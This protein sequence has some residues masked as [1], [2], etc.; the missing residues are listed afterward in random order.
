MDALGIKWIP[1]LLNVAD[2]KKW[3]KNP[4]KISDGA[5]A[6]LKRKIL[7]EGMHQV[8]TI[9]TDNTVLSGNQRLDILTELEWK[10]VW[11]MV[12]ERA[13]TPQERDKV[14]I[15]ANIIEGEWDSAILA[16][17]FDIPMLTDQGIKAI[18]LPRI[19]TGDEDNVPEV[20]PEAI[21][22]RGDIFTLGEH[23]LMC[24][25]ATSDEDM[26]KLM[27]G[28]RSNML[29]TD[30]PWN[31]G[32]GTDGNPKHKQRQGLV[33]DALGQDFFGFLV[34]SAKI[35][36]A[37]NDGDIY[38][39]MGCEQWPTIHAA[40]TGEGL[41]WSAT[42]IWVKDIFVLGRS[43]YHRRYEPIWY[44]WKEKSTYVADRKQDDVWEIPRPKRSDEHPTMKPVELMSRAILNSSNERD[45]VLDPFLG[46][47]STMVAAEKNRRKCYGMEIDPIYADV[48]IRRLLALYPD[49]PFR[50]LNRDVDVV[51]FRV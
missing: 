10:Q 23:R 18:N 51:Q 33:N 35:V 41:H 8:L 36:A 5:K 29:F 22:Q 3:D 47:G 25:D 32:I 2:L 27:G 42:I 28:V 39:V 26:V 48:I 6:R 40:L 14:G 1:Q 37:H 44:G 34:K 46:S 17:K 43:K 12:P 45:I 15:Q 20:R 9:D 21:T 7:E 13:L 50:C 31:V 11:C 49:I 16:S 24:G 38:C 30:P 4:R 19:T